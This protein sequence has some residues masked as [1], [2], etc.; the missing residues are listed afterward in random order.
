M[1]YFLTENRLKD[2]TPTLD[3]VDYKLINPLIKTNVLM[4]MQPILG[5]FFMEYLLAQYNSEALNGDE[6]ILVSKIQN[7]VAWRV[8][9][10]LVY[11]TSSQLTNKGI[12]TQDGLNSETAS[13]QRL[14]MLTGHYNSKAQHFENEL[15]NYLCANSSNYPNYTDKRNND[16]SV[17]ATPKKGESYDNGIFF[18]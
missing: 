6:K 5:T 2:L 11:T 13:V 10:D 9:S 8:I 1:I 16:C 4:W 18:L 14:G 15:V 7:A 3:N 17:F 12:Q